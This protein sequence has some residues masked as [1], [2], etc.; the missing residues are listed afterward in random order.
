MVEATYTPAMATNYCRSLF[1][2]MSIDK[3]NNSADIK[4]RVILKDEH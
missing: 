1:F 4:Q 2:S 3:T